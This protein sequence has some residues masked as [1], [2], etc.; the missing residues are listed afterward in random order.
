MTQWFSHAG[1]VRNQKACR[2][3]AFTQAHNDCQAGSGEPIHHFRTACLGMLWARVLGASVLG[4][5]EVQFERVVG[6]AGSSEVS[7]HW[8]RLASL[9]KGWT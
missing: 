5:C 4:E 1:E 2:G 3:S 8:M 6:G 9:R 7:H